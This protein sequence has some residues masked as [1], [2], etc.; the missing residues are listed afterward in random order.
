MN[1]SNLFSFK[2]V[3]STSLVAALLGTT[4]G[5]TVAG[6]GYGYDNRPVYRDNSNNDNANYNRAKQQLR[7][8]LRR[9]GYQVMDIRSDNYR[10][11][12]TLTAHVR[13][14]NQNYERQYA[15]PSLRLISSNRTG[16]SNNGEHNKYDKKHPNKNKYKNKGK[17]KDKYHDKHNKHRWS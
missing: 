8:N 17:H 10:G 6:P 4:V 13:K 16:W 12:R 3:V 2:T 11:D 14:D 7:E 9:Q 5:C 1:F 15:Y